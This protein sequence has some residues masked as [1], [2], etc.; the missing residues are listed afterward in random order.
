MLIRVVHNDTIPTSDADYEEVWI[1]GDEN[2]AQEEG[3]GLPASIL[4]GDIAGLEVGTWYSLADF[5]RMLAA[6]PNGIEGSTT[7]PIAEIGISGK[8]SFDLDVNQ[9][10][11][12]RM[13]CQA[14]LMHLSYLERNEGIWIRIE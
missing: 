9:T 3:E 10:A 2:S 1:G 7:I 11:A 14:V 6:S 8:R 4:A 12:A 13:I 5:I